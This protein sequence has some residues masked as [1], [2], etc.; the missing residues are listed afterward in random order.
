MGT[1]ESSSLLA[2]LITGV[3]ILCIAI[4]IVLGNKTNKTT[5][6]VGLGVVVISAL[7]IAVSGIGLYAKTT[8]SQDKSQ[9]YQDILGDN[10]GMQITALDTGGQ[11]ITYVLHGQDW[12][13]CVA[14]YSLNDKNHYVVDVESVMCQKNVPQ[15]VRDAQKNAASTTTPPTTASGNSVLP[16]TTTPPPAI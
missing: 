2:A 14:R 8:G 13:V 3:V 4:I 12:P 6:A 11:S 16:T 5:K 7:L 9:V 1:F 10:P 15:R